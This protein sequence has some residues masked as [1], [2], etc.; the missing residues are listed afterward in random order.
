MVQYDADGNGHEVK[1]KPYSYPDMIEYGEPKTR[2]PKSSIGIEKPVIT[3]VEGN[4][5][6]KW[7]SKETLNNNENYKI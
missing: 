2:K 3:D 5:N 1:F 7:V 4:T 6:N